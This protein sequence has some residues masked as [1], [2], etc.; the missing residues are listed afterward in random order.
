[1][2]FPGDGC[3]ARAQ[4]QA[5]EDLVEG[6]GDEEDDLF[7]ADRDGESEADED[8]VE[9]DAAFEEKA[10]H[11]EFFALLLLFRG[12][13][14]GFQGAEAVVVV[15]SGG[16]DVRVGRLPCELPG[17]DVWETCAP[18]YGLHDALRSS[19]SSASKLGS[20]LSF[21]HCLEQGI[22]HGTKQKLDLPGVI[23]SDNTGGFP[24]RTDLTSFVGPKTTS[25]SGDIPEHRDRPGLNIISAIV[26]IKIAAKAIAPARAGYC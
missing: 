12:R 24:V 8:A 1:M 21:V 11:E 20:G 14:F 9:E 19:R 23:S 16:V 15:K 7:A 26:I 6:D 22:T 2:G 25:S 10:L 13:F 18:L 4:G 5:F 3:D 17:V